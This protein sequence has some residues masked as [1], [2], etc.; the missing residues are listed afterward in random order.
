MSQ[1][2][3]FKW[4]YNNASC[5]NG[6]GYHFNYQYGFGRINAYAA[7][8]LA[9]SWPLQQTASN[10]KTIKGRFIENKANPTTELCKVYV[11]RD[12]TVKHAQQSVNIEIQGNPQD[13]DIFLISPS[14]TS[15]PL[16]YNLFNNTLEDKNLSY[17][18]ITKIYSSS[19]ALRLNSLIWTFDSTNFRGESSKGTWQ[20][21]IKINAEN[22]EKSNSKTKVQVNG[23]ELTLY[24]KANLIKQ[25]IG[26]Y[27]DDRF[28]IGNN[29]NISLTL[30]EG[31]D[32]ID[33]S[34]SNSTV[35]IQK[36]VEHY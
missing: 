1:L 24:G 17:E 30:N 14:G 23:L 22:K 3:Q 25:I 21:F 4:E 19:E 26:T 28:I 16:M 32:N 12:I 6:G 27:S 5:F 8:K 11:A 36:S 7:S 9:E 31:H 2:P 10:L 13:V 18:D 20:I 35:F 29:Y 15:S 34:G 33:F